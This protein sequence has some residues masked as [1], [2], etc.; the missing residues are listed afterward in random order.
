M[1]TLAKTLTA[2]AMTALGLTGIPATA[3]A[4][5][6]ANAISCKMSGQA[7]YMPGAH[8]LQRPDLVMSRDRA[9][10]CGNR[11]VSSLRAEFTGVDLSCGTRNV[12]AAGGW[13]TI[14]WNGSGAEQAS[15]AEVAI[16]EVTG[17]TAKV[18]GTVKSG[19]FTGRK[20]TGRFD[21]TLFG[22]TGTCISSSGLGNSITTTFEGDF[23]I[24]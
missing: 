7:Q 22:A 20:F 24:A 12:A 4:A 14:G 10:N 9:W 21:T 5:H 17:N 2:A 19:Q 13:V 18:S 11:G 1:P 23:S 6:A 8:L 15:K 16:N 3:T